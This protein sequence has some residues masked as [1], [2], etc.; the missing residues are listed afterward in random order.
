MKE[1]PIR[2]A[3]VPPLDKVRLFLSKI[4]NGFSSGVLSLRGIGPP[5]L[6]LEHVSG[7]QY[8]AIQSLVYLELPASS[9]AKVA[10]LDYYD[11]RL[12]INFPSQAHEIMSGIIE[13]IRDQMWEQKFYWET[14]SDSKDR[15]QLSKLM[16]MPAIP[17]VRNSGG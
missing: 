17:V 14:W 13:H 16:S 4:D 6:Q 7:E 8:K 5:P 15:I 9:A 1:N 11:G 10:K 3:P 12:F 2:P